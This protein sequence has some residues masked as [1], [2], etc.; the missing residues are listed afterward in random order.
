MR[1]LIP[2]A[3]AAS[4]ACSAKARIEQDAAR[5]RRRRRSRNRVAIHLR[6]AVARASLP[7]GNRRALYVFDATSN[8]C[9]P[10]AARGCQAK[11]GRSRRRRVPRRL[12]GDVPQLCALPAD[13]LVPC[14]TGPT[15]GS[16]FAT[17][18]A[19]C[20][21]KATVR[22]SRTIVLLRGGLPGYVR[23]RLREHPVSGSLLKPQTSRA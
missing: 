2:C 7:R 5:H 22:T 13:I 12:R 15:T 1:W 6:V 10:V 3:L 20:N 14:D 16:T 11:N 17:A 21:R 9:E 23:S 4:L 8:R 18:C 19:S